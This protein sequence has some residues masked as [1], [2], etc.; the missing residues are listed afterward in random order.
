MIGTK[1]GSYEII[2]EIGKG[3]LATVYRAFQPNVGRHVA[4]KV[5]RGSFD[6]NPDT[7]MRFQREARMVARL[8]HIHILPVYDFDGK[9]DPPYICLLYTS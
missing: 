9:N 8:E 6:E 3:G 1:L 2:E 7:V 4:V 5:L